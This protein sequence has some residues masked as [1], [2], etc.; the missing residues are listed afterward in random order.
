MIPHRTRNRGVSRRSLL[1][2]AYLVTV[3]VAVLLAHEGHAP[4]P[5]KGVSVDRARGH[6][7]LTRT[8]REALAVA[9]AEVELRPVE[10]TILA[11]AAV[12]LPWTHHGFATAKLPGRIS[13]V[14]V[15]PGQQ[16]KAGDVVAEVQSLD[17]ETLQF[18]ALT[19]QTE[20]GLSEKLVA[21]L[22]KSVEVGA[23]SGQTLI[24]A[25][26]KLAQ[27]KNGLVVAR[28]KWLSVGLS[29]ELF[30]SILKQGQSKAQLTLPVRAPVGGTI[31]HA[32]LTAGKVVEPSEHLA[33]IA[34]L[35]KVL[36]KVGVL[37]KDFARV[38]VGMT[39][40]IRMEAYPD[41]VFTTAISIVA[42]Y[43]DPVTH[44]GSVWAELKNPSGGEPR[45]VPGLNGRA[46]IVLPDDKPRIT[47]PISAIAREGVD[48]F[49]FVEEA[50]AFETSEYLKRS[51]ATGRRNGDRI[52]IIAGNLFPGDRVVVR[53]THEL[54][55][56]FAPEVLRLAPETE[57]AI[58]L[59]IQESKPGFVDE[60][61]DLDA[62]VDLPPSDR[63]TAA[64]PLP[65]TLAEV[66]TDRGKEV[67]AGDLLAHLVSP[68]LLNIQLELVRAGLALQLESSTLARIK[69]LP[70]IAKQRVWDTEG[71]VAALKNQ[72]DTLRR[73]LE[74]IGLEGADINGI[75]NQQKIFS[76]VPVRAPIS[77]V[78]VAFDQAIGQSV[79]AQQELF[80]IH[81]RSRPLVIGAV[82]ERDISRL[83]VGQPVRVRLVSHPDTFLRGQVVRSGR[84]LGK[85]SRSL[86]VWVELEQ[87]KL[88]PLLHGQ[89]ARM[90]VVLATHPVSVHVPRSAVV[91]DAGAEV[92][93]V[94]NEGGVFERR[95]VRIGRSDDRGLEILNGLAVGES[96]AVEGAAE[97]VTGFASLR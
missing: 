48:R 44:L 30:D 85:D 16:V 11:Y 17:L 63:G 96:I 4:L 7:V 46:E 93:F 72:V 61:V 38:A 39:V 71:R 74:T 70:A 91:G 18:D 57:R 88:R 78:V 82:S 81:D 75:V 69:D 20:I 87:E 95:S 66:F 59:R 28:T 25:E 2:L 23:I 64:T 9:T 26:S 94:K 83:I 84:T 76:A 52:E 33:E 22:K 14:H 3:G 5:S 51:V 67:R 31:I 79:A 19:S 6:V 15:V 56:L 13:R 77:G 90:T 55:G 47:V 1:A 60:T 12:E 86:T 89:L 53:G 32:E 27:A 24:D 37:E 58:G 21:E 97:L 50:N 49:V 42:P 80:S 45:F 62:A 65:G 43:L 34:D 68:E 73:K 36:V 92:V 29:A 8:A 10:G 40:K 35:S 54:S 41:E